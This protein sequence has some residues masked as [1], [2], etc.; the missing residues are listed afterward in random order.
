LQKRRLF[1][2]T[3]RALERRLVYF[4]HFQLNSW[5]RGANATCESES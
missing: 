2:T 1:Q 3:A 5:S 4:M